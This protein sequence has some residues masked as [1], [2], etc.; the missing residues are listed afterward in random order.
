[1]F[2]LSL[3]RRSVAAVFGTL[4]ACTFASPALAAG[5]HAVRSQSTTAVTVTATEFKFKLSKSTVPVGTVTFTVVNKGKIGHDF[6]IAGKKT[7]IIKPGKS[8]K[9]KVVFKKKGR[10]A[11]LCTVPGHAKLGMKGT[12]SVGVKATPPPTTTTTTTTTTTPTNSPGPGGTVQVSMFEYGFTFSPS[13]IPSGNVTFVMTDTG[14]VTHNLDI[15][16]VKVGPFLNAGQSASMTVNLQ[17]GHAYSFLCDVPGHAEL[18]MK[19][20][21]TPSG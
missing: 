17:A 6:K 19:G 20:T 12:L 3:T 7:P 18:G 5:S 21:F 9:L 8:A 1:M 16:G 15:Q 13:T 14:T 2:R 4:A 11:Y 10:Y